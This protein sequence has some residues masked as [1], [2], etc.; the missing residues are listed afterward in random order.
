[1]QTN[2]TL[3]DAFSRCHFSTESREIADIGIIAGNLRVAKVERAV[4][5]DVKFPF[6]VPYR[7]IYNAEREI[8]KAYML[9]YAKIYPK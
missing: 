9:N 7:K 2:K 4:E 6:I 1:M 5:A 3:S 8:M